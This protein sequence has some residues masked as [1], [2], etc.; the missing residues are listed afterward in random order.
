MLAALRHPLGLF[1]I[2]VLKK[3][4][5]LRTSAPKK[6]RRE[7]YLDLRF[8]LVRRDESNRAADQIAHRLYNRRKLRP[9][10]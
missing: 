9:W 6:G 8:H 10:R 2:L 1:I 5:H 7:A 3:G 4:P